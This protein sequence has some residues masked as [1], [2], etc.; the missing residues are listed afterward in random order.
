MNTPT[1]ILVMLIGLGAI[2]NDA[3][4]GGGSVSSKAVELTAKQAIKQC[5]YDIADTV[6]YDWEGHPDRRKFKNIKDI[7]AYR[8]EAY[9]TAIK[10][11]TDDPEQIRLSNAV[12]IAVDNSEINTGNYDAAYAKLY[13]ETLKKISDDLK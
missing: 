11:W 3:T 2:Y 6:K 9:S 5:L 13:E 8:D 1:R 7:Q 12:R 4:G 10:K